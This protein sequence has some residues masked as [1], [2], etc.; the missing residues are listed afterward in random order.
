M[1][2]KLFWTFH[3]YYLVV[4][5][6]LP[7]CFF[8]MSEREPQGMAWLSEAA[9]SPSISLATQRLWLK[10]AQ[11]FSRISSNEPK[12]AFVAS[13]F[14]EESGRFQFAKR[15]LKELQKWK[16]TVEPPFP[17]SWWPKYLLLD[18]LSPPF[19]PYDMQWNK[20]TLFKRLYRD[21]SASPPPFK[22]ISTVIIPRWAK[23]L[24]LP[25][26]PLLWSCYT[27]GSHQGAA[28]T[29]KEWNQ[30]EIRKMQAEQ[31]KGED[32]RRETIKEDRNN[33]NKEQ[34]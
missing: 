28:V 20:I 14:A 8:L 21:W 34:R 24:V 5:L 22:L 19:L 13:Q 4:S 29:R 18:G 6:R 15:H 11:F 9:I 3:I 16:R 12:A 27:S 25:H 31:R 23:V 17:H 10:L 30:K 32:G 33:A 1:A 26:L 2:L 7:V